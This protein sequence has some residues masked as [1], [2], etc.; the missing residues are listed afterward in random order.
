[1][2]TRHG[3][4]TLVQEHRFHLVDDDGAHKLFI[5][6][7]DAPLE[8]QDLERLEK[9]ASH[10]RVSYEDA[11]GMIAATAHDVVPAQHAMKPSDR[12]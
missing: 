10:V 7:H 9:S 12:H 3:V 11:P 2:H 6:S 8:W 5:L 4:I 1:M